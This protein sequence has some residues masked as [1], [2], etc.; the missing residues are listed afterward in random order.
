MS[1]KSIHDHKKLVGAAGFEPASHI[2]VFSKINVLVIKKSG[3]S[4][5]TDNY[6]RNLC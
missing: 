1:I 2:T 5:F 3:Y 4:T 6:L